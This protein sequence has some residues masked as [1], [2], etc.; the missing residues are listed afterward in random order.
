MPLTT[1]PWYGNHMDGWPGWAMLIG[2]LVFLLLV[3]GGVAV[4]I[5][6]AGRPADQRQG[7]QGAAVR[8]S[9]AEELLA[10]RFA[11]GEIDAEEYRHRLDT[12]RDERHDS[13][14]IA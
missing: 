7:D 4:L 6:Y 14:P 3:A 13:R 8:R 9:T 1:M 2:W 10:E 11:R 5:R 12:L